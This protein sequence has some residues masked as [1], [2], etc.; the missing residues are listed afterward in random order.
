LV[1][2][3]S[4]NSTSTGI[5]RDRRIPINDGTTAIS[6]RSS[7]L[8]RRLR[9]PLLLAL[10]GALAANPGRAE[11]A[12][13]NAVTAAT[14]AFGTVVGTQVIGLYSPTNARGFSPTQA[15]NLR[16]EGFYYDQ[17]SM[18]ANPYLFSGSDMR[19]GI[20]AQ[21]Y[22]F[23]SP[24]GIADYR[25]RIPQNSAG[26]SVVLIRGPL[27]LLSV[28][29]D[30][31]YPLVPEAVSIGLDLGYAHDFDY[32]YALSSLRRAISLLV[33]IEPREGTEII[34]FFGYVNNTERRETPF[35]YANGTDPMPFFQAQDLPTQEW[36]TWAWNQITAGAI[37]RSV[38]SGP[39]SV[40][41]GIFR[42]VDEHATNFNDLF[43]NLASDGTAS[44]VLD[45]PPAQR[46]GS[47]SGDLRIVRA[48]GEGPH[49]RE[50]TLAFR[51]RHVD[52]EYGGDSITDLG[53][54]SLQDFRVLPEPPLA[55]SAQSR[56]VVQQSGVGVNYSESWNGVGSLNIGLLRTDYSRVITSPG[57]PTENQHSTETLPTVSLT[58]DATPVATF[59]GSY[60]RGLEDSLTAPASTVNRGEPPPATPTWQADAG[61]RVSPGAKLKLLLGA[62]TIH[63]TYFGVDTA[64]VYRSLGEISSQG[65]ESSATLTDRGG[66]TVVAGAVW[67][68]PD[69]Q[70]PEQGGGGSVPVG[71][72]PRT[73]NVNVDY[74]PARWNRWAA[75]LNWTSLSSRVQTSDGSYS[76]APLKTLNV[77]VR[78]G[79]GLFGGKCSI[80][81]DAGNVTNAAG[82]TISPVYQLTPQLQRNYTLTLSADL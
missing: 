31:Q 15:E 48:T 38:L 72:V 54:T 73:I 65:I 19:V 66:L 69:V 34:P 59:Y 49:R 58:F 24:S 44:H 55:F 79:F 61:V 6:A 17:Q 68:R 21:S 75:S 33:R 2:V 3:R 47:Y 40:R 71:P 13:D 76:L 5:R 11:R 14:D 10:V 36:T 26:A 41:A 30:T 8:R 60:T 51:A 77:G 28:E 64:N 56:D 78:Y 46:A 22:A 62:F 43:L 50:L 81:F 39:W 23:P 25:L 42:S 52:R 32:A 12:A 4:S 70:I 82:L 35:V 18:G 1:L 20:A 63:K 37:A 7:N 29:L 45:V 53:A 74:S 27:E 16:I 57:E 9:Y 67:L 80:R